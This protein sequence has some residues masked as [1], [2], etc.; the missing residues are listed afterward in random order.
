MVFFV[1]LVAPFYATSVVGVLLVEEVEVAVEDLVAFLDNFN[2]LPRFL[3]GQ[4]LNMQVDFK[5]ILR[6]IKRL[7]Q[8]WVICHQPEVVQG[9]QS[10][11]KHLSLVLEY[12]DLY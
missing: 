7:K 6:I 9:H 5:Q 3:Q 1:L 11:N 4:L 2:R 10:F 12:V 8:A